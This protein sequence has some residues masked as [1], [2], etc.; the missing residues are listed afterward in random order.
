MKKC[1][2][3]Y[4]VG[5]L[6]LWI[7]TETYFLVQGSVRAVHYADLEA[8]ERDRFFPLPTESYAS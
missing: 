3:I 1:V 8:V 6:E 4:R 2:D 7:G 5:S